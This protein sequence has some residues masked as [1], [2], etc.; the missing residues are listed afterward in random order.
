MNTTITS[1]NLYINTN[2]T[3]GTFARPYDSSQGM[4][5]NLLIIMLLGLA[6]F[7]LYI[8]YRVWKSIRDEERGK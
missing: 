2:P 6:L 4:S 5:S 1:I 3:K 7:T 8:V